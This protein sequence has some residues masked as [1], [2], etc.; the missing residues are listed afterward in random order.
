[1]KSRMTIATSFACR[2]E[3]A[4]VHIVMYI[5]MGII[6]NNIEMVLADCKSHRFQSPIEGHTCDIPEHINSSVI[7]HHHC[8][9]ACIR[10]KD[11]T[12]TVYDNQRSVC[13]ALSHPCVLLK[14]RVGYV[15]QAFHHRCVEWVPY[16][17]NIPVYSIN[18]R[19][20]TGETYIG[21]VFIN[22][23]LVLGK[24]VP[25]LNKFFSVHPSGTS[26]VRLDTGYEKLVVDASCSVTWVWYN[27][28]KGQH[29]PTGALMGGYLAATGTPL[30]VSRIMPTADRLIIGYYNPLNR[31]AWG[32]F[33]GIKSGDTFEVI[34]IQPLSDNP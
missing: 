8:T 22:D 5:V 34:V 15:Y 13:M 2:L 14:P 9:M 17:E 18:E 30:Y 23:D 1:M 10:S 7:E 25:S 29:L 33:S 19:I 28:T 32:L 26:E 24:V 12:A 6:S 11:C 21:R 27:A 3:M 4:I 31:M 20:I 16:S